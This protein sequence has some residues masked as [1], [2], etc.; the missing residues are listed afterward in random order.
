MV[1]LFLF[2]GTT[3]TRRYNFEQLAK[4][5]QIPVESFYGHSHHLLFNA[6]AVL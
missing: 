2:F 1:F 5:E 3:V 4:N 6:Y